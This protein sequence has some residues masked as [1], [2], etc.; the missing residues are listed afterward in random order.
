[1]IESSAESKERECIESQKRAFKAEQQQYIARVKEECASVSSEI[2]LLVGG[3]PTA[4]AAEFA[5]KLEIESVEETLAGYYPRDLVRNYTSLDTIS[6]ET[7]AEAYKLYTAIERGAARLKSATVASTIYS[8][9]STMLSRATKSGTTGAVTSLIFVAALLLLLVVSPFLF[10]SIFTVLGL[11]AVLS[12]VLSRRLLNR[13]YALRMFLNSSYDEDIFKRDT[14]L[15]MNDVKNLLG[16]V[17]D[18]YISQINTREFKVN[19]K[20]LAELRGSLS[21]QQDL[22]RQQIA[23]SKSQIEAKTQ[24]A[25]E[26]LEQLDAAVKQ[27]EERARTARKDF[28]ETVTW[29]HE[30]ME[31]LLLDVSAENRVIGCKWTKGNS[32]YYAKSFDALQNFWQLAIYQSMLHMHPD[33]AGQIVLDYKYMGSNLM[34]FS[35]VKP[36][37]LSLLIEQEDIAL[38]VARIKSD[39]R[40]RCSNILKSC[41]SLDDFNKLM[42]GYDSPGEAYVIVH[43][44]GLKSVSEDLLNF[45]RNG[46]KVGYFFKVYL[47]SEELTSLGKDFPLS[48]VQEIAEL[49]DTVVPRSVAAVQRLLSGDT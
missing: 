44:C 16:E 41:S 45:L 30:W 12:G 10:L 18:E 27:Q 24:E 26:L 1:M 5:G 34:Q 37:L 39:I 7:D 13:L 47:T 33:F 43:I 17:A 2:E 25:R 29:K 32:L 21:R 35:A 40:A 11:S 48:E 49:Q 36:V 9:V 20:D 38:R 22:I 3:M 46:P 8:S 28:L 14:E 19:E 23:N 15:I 31:G 42:A 6:L 4:K